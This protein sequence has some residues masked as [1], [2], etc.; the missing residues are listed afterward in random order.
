MGLMG[1]V[2]VIVSLGVVIGIII[3]IIPSQKQK[4]MEEKLREYT[5]ISGFEPTKKVMGADGEAGLAI[6]EKRKKVC[7]IKQNYDAKISLYVISYRDILASEIY[8]GGQTVT[9]TSRASQ[10]G[11]TLIGGLALGG[12]GA[13]I[14]GLSGKKTSSDK[15]ERIDL[16]LTVNR[17][18]API[19]EVNF[20]A[21]ESKKGGFLYNTAIEQ[22]RHW[23][24]LMEVLIKRADEE[25]KREEKKKEV[26]KIENK[27][28]ADELMKLVQLKEQGILSEKEFLEQ[29]AK[30]LSIN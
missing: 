10:L 2:I 16:R 7:L 11:G 9:K 15:I 24:G 1:W 13:I 21:N 29:K 14:G 22:A 30:L 12:V 5:R 28:V 17:T 8:E 25:D 27:S 20:I 6:D 19:H 26:K 4:D 3:A 23:H 18:N